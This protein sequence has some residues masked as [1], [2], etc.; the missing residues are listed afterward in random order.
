MSFVTAAVRRIDEGH[1]HMIG[2]RRHAAKQER[3]LDT[4]DAAS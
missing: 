3:P 1:S 2:C 4:A